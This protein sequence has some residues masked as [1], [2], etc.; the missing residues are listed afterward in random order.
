MSALNMGTLCPSETL[1][2]IYQSAHCHKP[3]HQNMVFTYFVNLE[4]HI[5]LKM[6][7]NLS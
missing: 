6:E 1:S 3:E 4:N 7:K 2:T 5:Y